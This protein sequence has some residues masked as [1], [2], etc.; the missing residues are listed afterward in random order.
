MEPA[1]N[2][3]VEDLGEARAAPVERADPRFD[4]EVRYARQCRFRAS[5]HLQLD[6]LDVDLDQVDRAETLGR[7]V[8][9]EPEDRHLD[10]ADLARPIL[11]LPPSRRLW[12]EQ[13]VRNLRLGEHLEPSLPCPRPQRRLSQPDARI[14]A[15]ELAAAGE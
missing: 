5:E 9:V 2:Q 14:L 11:D 1:R 7:G 8:V 10:L 4:E 6:S 15:I 3:V 13:G 12:L